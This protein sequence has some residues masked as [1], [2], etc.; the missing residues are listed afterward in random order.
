MDDQA[1]TGQAQEQTETS[2]ETEKAPENAN[3]GDA[4]EGQTG[5][6]ASDAEGTKED[7]GAAE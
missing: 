6:A 2:T 1:Q 5:E 7:D 4:C 3:D